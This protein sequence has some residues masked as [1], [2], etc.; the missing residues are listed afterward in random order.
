MKFKIIIV[1]LA[2][3]LVMPMANAAMIAYAEKSQSWRNSMTLRLNTL[4]ILSYGKFKYN[5]KLYSSLDV[6]VKY[7]MG[8]TNLWGWYQY[9]KKPVTFKVLLDDGL[10]D[11]YWGT[12]PYIGYNQHIAYY[13]LVTPA[14][15]RSQVTRTYKTSISINSFNALLCR[16]GT[17]I[18]YV[19][20]SC[21]NMWT[22]NDRTS[23]GIWLGFDVKASASNYLDYARIEFW[24]PGTAPVG[25]PMEDEGAGPLST[26]FLALTFIIAVTGA[27]AYVI[28][29]D[30]KPALHRTA[31]RR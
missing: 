21:I 7:K 19:P 13:N 15:G 12:I 6:V 10:K 31:R 14:N 1:L 29:E 22:S 20:S 25:Y 2:V 26:I 8:G 9:D 23:Y 28:L 4:P 3:M 16:S 24:E 11:P 27:L 17:A 18:D 30:Y 5:G